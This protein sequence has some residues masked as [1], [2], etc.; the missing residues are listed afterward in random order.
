MT[1]SKKDRM[2]LVF[3]GHGSPMNAIEENSY[4]RSLN[5][6]GRGDAQAGGGPGRFSTL[7]DEGHLRLLRP[8]AR[9]DP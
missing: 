3:I 1:T 2:P 7:A 9:N 6:L 8:K 4:T 5:E